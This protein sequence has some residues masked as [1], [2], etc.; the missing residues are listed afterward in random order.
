MGTARAAGT[1]RASAAVASVGDHL[2]SAGG[3]EQRK[4]ALGC[5]TLA[6]YAGCCRIGIFEAAHQ[7]KF[8]LAVLANIFINRHRVF[9]PLII[10]N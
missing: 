2:A 1:A 3:I 6:V 4:F 7:L 8:P 10:S 5:L 9:N